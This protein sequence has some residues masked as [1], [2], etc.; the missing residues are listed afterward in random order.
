MQSGGKVNTFSGEKSQNLMRSGY[1]KERND[2]SV[3]IL[4]KSD[5]GG[6]R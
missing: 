1:V 2:I 4:G 3:V 5:P 6:K